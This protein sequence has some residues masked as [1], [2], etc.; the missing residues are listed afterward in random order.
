MDRIA[1]LDPARL[2]RLQD[3]TALLHSES[4]EERAQEPGEARIDQA[5]AAPGSPNDVVIEAVDRDDEFA[6]EGL[7]RAAGLRPV[8]GS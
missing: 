1:E 6:R 2:R 7:E 8:S 3:L 4:A 5:L